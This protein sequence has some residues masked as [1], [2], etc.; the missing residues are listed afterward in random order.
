M[1]DT[2]F[3]GKATDEV[4]AVFVQLVW[5]AML[6]HTPDPL[7]QRLHLLTAFVV[8]AAAVWLLRAGFAD[9]A[10]RVRVAPAGWVLGGLLAMQV[11]L[12]VEAWMTKFGELPL[13]NCLV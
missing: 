12:G 11:A 10:A 4:I 1:M 3:C 8:V 2:V 13:G 6:R 7:N 5:G 9:P